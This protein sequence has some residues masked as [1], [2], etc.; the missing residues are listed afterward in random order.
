MPN[1]RAAVDRP[2]FEPGTICSAT[3]ISRQRAFPSRQQLTGFLVGLSYRSK[4]G[5]G[6]FEPPMT[7]TVPES[8]LFP[9]LRVAYLSVPPR[10]T[11]SVRKVGGRSSVLRRIHHN[12][13]LES[14]A[15]VHMVVFKEISDFVAHN[16]AVID[17]RDSV[18]C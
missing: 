9:A 3:V 13:V 12:L 10:S 5:C 14:T 16:L 4:V 11:I 7:G 8:Y 6:G 17:H 18:L 1:L 15:N 2:G